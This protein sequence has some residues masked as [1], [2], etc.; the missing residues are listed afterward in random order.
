[1]FQVA[2]WTLGHFEDSCYRETVLCFRF[3]S[4]S[5][6][7]VVL[8]AFEDFSCHPVVL[9]VVEYFSY[10]DVIVGAFEGFNCHLV[11][12]SLGF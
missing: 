6:R 7:D 2:L 12:Y 1:M 5:Y 8:G 10:R 11:S 9:G 3:E 4:F